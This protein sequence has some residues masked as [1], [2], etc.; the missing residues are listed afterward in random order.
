MQ[1]IVVNQADTAILQQLIDNFISKVL[2]FWNLEYQKNI[3]KPRAEGEETALELLR[4]NSPNTTNGL[5]EGT[6]YDFI[7]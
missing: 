7:P 2:N 4:G 1:F 3:R 6:A 5:N